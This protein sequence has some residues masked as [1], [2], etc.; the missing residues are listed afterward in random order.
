[1]ESSGGQEELMEERT[2]HSNSPTG[3]ELHP[4]PSTGST[5][6]KVGQFPWENR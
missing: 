3:P 1:M 5:D 2:H 6:L 4:N